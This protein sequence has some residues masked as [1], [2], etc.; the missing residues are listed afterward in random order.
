MKFIQTVIAILITSSIALSQ[1]KELKSIY[2]EIDSILKKEAQYYES[3][4]Q[5]SRFYCDY[6]DRYGSRIKNKFNR[7]Y[8]IE[9]LIYLEKYMYDSL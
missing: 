1:N 3:N 4:N 6:F 7:K 2:C 9:T 8:E 5:Y